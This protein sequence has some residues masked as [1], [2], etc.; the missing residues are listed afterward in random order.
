[1]LQEHYFI[2]NIINEGSLSPSY[3]SIDEL[4]EKLDAHVR[5][6]ERN[7]FPLIEKTI[8]PEERQSI[9]KVLENEKDH[10]CMSY[11]QKFWE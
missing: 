1:M 7:L 8:T 2:K 5:F 6:E 4:R 11:R 3:K 10:N 9:G